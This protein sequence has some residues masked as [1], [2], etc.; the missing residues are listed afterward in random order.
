[1]RIHIAAQKT[2]FINSHEKNDNRGVKQHV[3]NY[4]PQF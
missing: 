4:R 1:M 3:V 2:Y